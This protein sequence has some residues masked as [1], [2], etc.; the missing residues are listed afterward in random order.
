M[1]YTRLEPTPIAPLDG[2]RRSSSSRVTPRLELTHRDN[3]V[4]RCAG[5]MAAAKRPVDEGSLDVAGAE[6]GEACKMPRKK[7][8]KKKKKAARPGHEA[9]HDADW[10]EREVNAPKER[11]ATYLRHKAA[12]TLDQAGPPSSPGPWALAFVANARTHT[13]TR[14]SRVTLHPVS[15]LYFSLLYSLPH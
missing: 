8:T 6:R 13:H 7:K 15:L 2:I 10:E 5:G 12:G 1:V 3:V 14:C 9:A 11:E 4:L